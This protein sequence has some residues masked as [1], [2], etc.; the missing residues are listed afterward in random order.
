MN[1]ENAG[2]ECHTKGKK[3]GNARCEHRNRKS[4]LSANLPVYPSIYLLITSV[5]AYLRLMLTSV[6]FS[7]L[8]HTLHAFES[9]FREAAQRGVRVGAIVLDSKSRDGEKE[10]LRLP[11]HDRW[12][13][14][15]PLETNWVLVLLHA[16]LRACL[17]AYHEETRGS[18]IR[19]NVASP[20]C[21]IS[22]GVELSRC[23]QLLSIYLSIYL[24]IT[25]LVICLLLAS[26]LLNKD[27]TK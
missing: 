11:R 1:T 22:F 9:F 10:R 18:L 6:S 20:S 24:L 3:R 13:G 23:V 12:T 15:S 17:C 2:L 19:R 5:L 14:S 27:I 25:R 7:F 26:V 4:L 8:F 21:E 16:V